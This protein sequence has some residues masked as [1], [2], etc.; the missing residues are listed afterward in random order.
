MTKDNDVREMLC[1][2]LLQRN[3]IQNP[4]MN[5]VAISRLLTTGFGE[6]FCFFIKELE[7]IS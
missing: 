6:D 1:D 2:I 3:L 5:V 7:G 4:S